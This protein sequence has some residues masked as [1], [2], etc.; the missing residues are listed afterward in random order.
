VFRY[1]TTFELVACR[2]VCQA[3]LRAARVRTTAAPR[4]DL[5][6][7][8]VTAHMVQVVAVKKPQQLVLDWTNI[9]KQQVR[10]V[11]SIVYVLLCQQLFKNQCSGSVTFWYGSVPVP[12]VN[13]FGCGSGSI[14]KSSVTFR[15]HKNLFFSYFQMFY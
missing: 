15:M 3:W 8:K 12:L 11:I 2:S 6:G 5:S 10:S 9:S 13:R 1:L 7:M 14:P 4:L